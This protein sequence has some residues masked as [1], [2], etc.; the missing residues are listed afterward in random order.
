[1]KL[2]REEGVRLRQQNKGGKKTFD[3]QHLRDLILT[4]KTKIFKVALF[5]PGDTM[6]AVEAI[7]SDHQR[8][9]YPKTEVADFFLKK[10]LGCTL[11]DDP[12][13]ITKR[14]YEA[15]EGYFN[16]HISDPIVRDKYYNHLVSELNSEKS[17]FSPQT[18]A[19]SYLKTRDRQ[20]YLDY[21]SSQNVPVNSF[22]KDLSLVEKRLDKRLIE[23][24][25]G[26][27]IIAPND[28]SEARLT[29]TKLSTG[30]VKAEVQDF[31][32]TIRAK[33]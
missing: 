3:I 4:Q 8:G 23:F 14:F 18:F 10:F 24:R 21:L 27:R 19:Q 25:S 1:M 2:E 7:A 32:E 26:I 17:I 33:P 9:Y 12:E 16:E 31:L 20:S 5:Q 28:V 6:E 29:L 15:S 13:V 22:V 11:I 30:E